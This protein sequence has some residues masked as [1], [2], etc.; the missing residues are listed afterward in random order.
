MR[1]LKL[2]V[3]AARVAHG[4]FLI[5]W[6]VSNVVDEH[7]AADVRLSEVGRFLQMHEGTGVQMAST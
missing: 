4:Y 1:I 7:R 5:L 3:H 2:V 6:R